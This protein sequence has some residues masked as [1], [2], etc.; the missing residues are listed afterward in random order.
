MIARRVKLEVHGQAC[1]LA[2][3]QIVR[4]AC[5]ATPKARLGF[6][7]GAKFSRGR[8][9]GN[10]FENPCS[11]QAARDQEFPEGFLSCRCTPLQSL[12]LRPYIVPLFV[13]GGRACLLR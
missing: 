1:Q 10:L 13:T 3:A 2:D 8:L 6:D 5:A 4:K 12:Q 7:G 11:G 9:Y